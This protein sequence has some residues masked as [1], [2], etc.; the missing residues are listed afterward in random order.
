MTEAGGAGP[1]PDVGR[2]DLL[3]LDGDQ[4]RDD[5]VHRPLIRSQEKLALE[6]G[7]VEPAAGEDHAS[8]VPTDAARS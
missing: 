5:L 3:G 1:Q 6:V 4:V 2:V 8:T 7:A